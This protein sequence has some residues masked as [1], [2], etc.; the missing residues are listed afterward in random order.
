MIARDKS[1]SL[2]GTKN[3]NRFAWISASLMGDIQTFVDGI[4]LFLQNKGN[5]I[6]AASRGGGNVTLPITVN[7]GLEVVSALY[8]GK[9][10]YKDGR[11]YNAADNVRKFVLR[12]FSHSGVMIPLL[13][14]DGVRNGIDRLLF[15]RR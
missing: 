12:Y 5:P 1:T 10:E 13:L 3:P 7:T 4:S 14:W 15:P 8:I 2:A 11:V 6:Y 9:T